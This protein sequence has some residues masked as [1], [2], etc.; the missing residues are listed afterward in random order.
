[1][2]AMQT[3]GSGR[4]DAVALGVGERADDQLAAV[5]IDG[6]MKR[7]LVQGAGR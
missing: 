6:V 7:G 2:G 3:E 5:G 4:G 1:M